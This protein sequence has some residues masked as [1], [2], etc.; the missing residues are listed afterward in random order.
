MEAMEVI[1]RAAQSIKGDEQ[2]A[3][4]GVRD[5]GVMPYKATAVKTKKRPGPKEAK[6]SRAKKSPESGRRG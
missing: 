2:A 1:R 4:G 5:G 6:N 3:A